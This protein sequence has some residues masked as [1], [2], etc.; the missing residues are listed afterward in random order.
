[1]EPRRPVR[2]E[3]LLAR[4]HILYV[5]RKVIKFPGNHRLA[6]ISRWLRRGSHRAPEI[7]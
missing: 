7:K 2:K 4:F 6:R 1:M 3:E 5:M